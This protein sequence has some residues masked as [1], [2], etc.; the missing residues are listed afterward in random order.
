MTTTSHTPKPFSMMADALES[1]AETFEQAAAN[2]PES[3]RRAARVTKRALGLGIFKAI[4]G[5]SYGIVY[6]G[7]FITEL[8]P[9]Q[10][11]VRRA[12]REGAEAAIDARLKAHN[13]NRP[14]VSFDPHHEEEAPAKATPKPVS[15]ATPKVSAKVSTKVS[16]KP[17]LKA[18]KKRAEKF[19]AA[20]KGLKPPIV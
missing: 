2:A 7:T 17:A 15:K 12:L 13:R 14:M 10:G 9:E 18:V 1:A 16:A 11:T 5:I 6:S 19:D 3:A 8:L 4:Y 20:A